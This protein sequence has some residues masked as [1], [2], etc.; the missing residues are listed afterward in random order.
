V[1]LGGFLVTLSRLHF[2]IFEK[3]GKMLK[4]STHS[5]KRER[6]ETQNNIFIGGFDD[7][8]VQLLRF[9]GQ[10]EAQGV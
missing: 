8:F 10:S 5:G 1:V 2:E 4:D 9:G 7:E 6:N 3:Y